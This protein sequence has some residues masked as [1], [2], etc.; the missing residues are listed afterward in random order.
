MCVGELRSC[1]P[2]PVPDSIFA[3]RWPLVATIRVGTPRAP[4]ATAPAGEYAVAEGAAYFALRRNSAEGRLQNLPH[5]SAIRL[6]E[7]PKR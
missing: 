1:E 6:A 2:E 3:R 4:A 5:P 7:V